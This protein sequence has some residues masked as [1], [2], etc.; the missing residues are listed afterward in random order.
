MFF[1][2]WRKRRVLFA[3]F[4]AIQKKSV[5]LWEAYWGRH[6]WATKLP[7][8][9]LHVS[10]PTV[11][12]LTL[13]NFF[14]IIILHVRAHTIFFALNSRFEVVCWSYKRRW[15]TLREEHPFPTNPAADC[16]AGTLWCLSLKC[17]TCWGISRWRKPWQPSSSAAFWRA[18]SLRGNVLRYS[19]DTAERGERLRAKQHSELKKSGYFYARTARY[20]S[21]CNPLKS[22]NVEETTADGSLF[23]S[24]VSIRT[25]LQIWLG[26]LHSPR[27]EWG[28][29]KK[30]RTLAG[31]LEK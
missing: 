27:R 6:E 21:E 12:S 17:C 15:R 23:P 16:G 4:V 31:R 7:L 1:I 2:S 20:T 13:C 22:K 8:T 30:N 9:P 10:H 14:Q 24:I 25:L 29:K 18:L 28:K 5:I 26:G 11:W 3:G 19:K